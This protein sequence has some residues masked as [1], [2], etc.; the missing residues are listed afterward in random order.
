MSQQPSKRK[1]LPNRPRQLMMGG[2]FGVLLVCLAA[3]TLSFS[4]YTPDDAYFVDGT[5]GQLALWM[6]DQSAEDDVES[7]LGG[8]AQSRVPDE[9][10]RLDAT[11]LLNEMSSGL[12]IYGVLL[13][14][15]T[16]M[17]AVGLVLGWQYHRIILVVALV[18]IN[19]LIFLLPPVPDNHTVSLVLLSI[20][21]LGVS[22]MLFSDRLERAVGFLVILSLFTV[23]WEGTK[24]ITGALDYSISV[25]APTLEY[26][27]YA[28][29]DATL[30]ALEN[31]EI[32]LA[33]IDQKDVRDLMPIFPD[34]PDDAEA[35]FEYADL[36]Y[37]RNFERE[38]TQWVFPVE[39]ELAGRVAMVVPAA[40]AETITSSTQFGNLQVGAISESFAEID[41]LLE[42]R[43]VILLDLG[44]T[45]DLN[46]P[47]LQSIS[48]ALMQP[49]RRNGPFLLVRI[50]ADAALYTWTEAI[51]GFL[52]GGAFG[53]MLGTLFAHVAFLQRSLLPYVIASQTIP[54]IALA[55][56]IVIWLRD[57]HPLIPVAVISAYL[58]FFPVTINTLRGLQSPDPAA[59]RLMQSYAA[60]TWQT[61]WK[62]R[63]PA[64]LPFIF[65]ALKVSAT[66]SVVGAIIGELP[67]GVRDG[68]GRALL[69]FS[70]DYSLVSTPKLWGAIFMSALVGIVFFLIVS[71]IEKLVIRGYE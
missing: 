67:S 66:A 39:P 26:T 70:S 1:Q 56:M 16:S 49:A 54:I 68:L 30:T 42:S 47:H 59:F 38:A 46:L 43:T 32:D 3:L 62:L 61:M 41:F 45:N 18:G 34:D 51:L 50:L 22:I 44:I 8:Y 20:T 63:F 17:G 19:L 35:E 25:A 55:P 12:T 4:R 6:S 53:F 28:S 29:L 36:R 13:I 15:V 11:I 31:D 24:A 60:T 37:V 69:D 5:L 27:S 33:L 71:L 2:V 52:I 23:A 64:A 58:T 9:V 14:I 21:L 57:T 7:L 48:E 40:S 10:E 65:T